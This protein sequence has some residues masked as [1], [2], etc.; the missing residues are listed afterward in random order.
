MNQHCH[1]RNAVKHLVKKGTS[2]G[3]TPVGMIGQG[4]QENKKA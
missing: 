1:Q 2:N 4:Q 3:R